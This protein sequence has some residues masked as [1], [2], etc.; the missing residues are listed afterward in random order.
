M[1]GGCCCHRKEG[2]SAGNFHP[3]FLHQSHQD[4]SVL[5]IRSSLLS[6]LLLHS[7]ACGFN[8]SGRQW[9]QPCMKKKKK[10]HLQTSVELHQT[11]LSGRR[12]LGV[13]EWERAALQRLQNQS[14]EPQRGARLWTLSAS[15]C[16]ASS[17]HFQDR[18][19]LVDSLVVERI[20][21]A[22]LAVRVPHSVSFRHNQS[23][24]VIN[25]DL[26]SRETR[27]AFVKATFYT[28][29]TSPDI[30]TISRGCWCRFTD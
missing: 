24:I 29:N 4:K 21:A 27:P 10:L 23:K 2:V 20:N 3:S 16:I 12:I 1:Q 18:F 22:A 5:F 17:F 11:N 26:E 28:V 25:V 14:A 7:S 19:L 6:L 30:P 9:K 15:L 8:Y 13:G